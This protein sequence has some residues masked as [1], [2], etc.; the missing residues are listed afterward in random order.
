MTLELIR[1]LEVFDPISFGDLWVD[2]IGIGAS[3]SRIAVGI[4]KLGIRNVRTFDDD[5]VAALNV[6]NQAYGLNH[7]DML[8]S[9]ALNAFIKEQTGM[10]IDARRERVDGS[11]RLG[12]IVFLLVDTMTEG[13]GCRQ[14]IW[15][16]ALRYKPHVKLVIET[17]MGKNSG[18]VYTVNPSNPVHVRGWESTLYPDKEAEVSA[19]GTSISVGP[20]A[21]TLSGLAQWQLIRWH[22]AQEELRVG[23]VPS[24]KPE[25]E[26]IFSLQPMMIHTRDFN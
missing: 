22:R 17:R 23:K 5:V 11:Q 4:K 15:N 16:K 13:N 12:D 24:D 26:L 20:T 2:I 7:V 14:A 1:H 8:K 18:R 19:C 21:E 6:P 9:E 10:E 3:G 25:N